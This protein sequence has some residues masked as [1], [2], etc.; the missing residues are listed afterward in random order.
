MNLKAALTTSIGKASQTATKKKK[1]TMVSS[2]TEGEKITINT[3]RTGGMTTIETT[4]EDGIEGVGTRVTRTTAKEATKITRTEDKSGTTGAR[5][6]L[7]GRSN[8][9]ATRS[10]GTKSSTNKQSTTIQTTE[11]TMLTATSFSSM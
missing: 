2:G 9:E 11:S 1:T 6:G 10:S 8:T 3:I 4:E 7:R 5:M